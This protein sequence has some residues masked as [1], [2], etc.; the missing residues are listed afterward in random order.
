MF[1]NQQFKLF[2]FGKFPQSSFAKFIPLRRKHFYRSM[3]F[4]T[5]DC[6][7]M[8]P[9]SIISESVLLKSSSSTPYFNATASAVLLKVG[10]I[11]WIV[12]NILQVIF[13][14][15][16]QYFTNNYRQYISTHYN[17]SQHLIWCFITLWID[18]FSFL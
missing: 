4:N 1:D 13:T 12:I 8:Y 2:C 3:K 7:F 16:Y 10:I 14:I 5:A 6:F 18:I 9:F 11:L 17:Y 15:N